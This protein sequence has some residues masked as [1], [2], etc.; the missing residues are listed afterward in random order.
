MVEMRPSVYKAS[1]CVP[2]NTYAV[3]VV[4]IILS[5]LAV[6]GIL[7][8]YHWFDFQCVCVGEA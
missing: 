7:F 2:C 1:H 5:E 3:L 4:E 8:L 6:G